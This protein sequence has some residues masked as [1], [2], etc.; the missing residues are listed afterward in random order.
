MAGY[1][2]VTN[3][4]STFP[5]GDGRGGMS[6]YAIGHDGRLTLLGQTDVTN[7]PVTPGTTFPTDEVAELR[8]PVSVRGL[9][10]ARHGAAAGEHQHE[11]HRR[12]PRR[13][14]RQPD[15]HP[16]D[17]GQRC[18]T[19]CREWRRPRQTLPPGASAFGGVRAPLAPT[20]RLYSPS[21]DAIRT[22]WVSFVPE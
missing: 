1:A 21:I 3:S 8:Q 19:E 4:L 16:D 6:R 13:A 20:R 18:P 9:A 22:R 5:P 2:F 14:G 11:S 7:D 15:P 12:L 10:V 17:A